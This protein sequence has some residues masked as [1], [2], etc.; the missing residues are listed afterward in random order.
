MV[1]SS[2]CYQ[3]QCC[4]HHIDD[5]VKQHHAMSSRFFP[6]QFCMSP[7]IS[8]IP[9]CQPSWPNKCAPRKT[10]HRMHI[11][12]QLHHAPIT[13][14]LSFVKPSTSRPSGC[15][16]SNELITHQ[17]LAR[18]I[19]AM[20]VNQ[21]LSASRL[22]CSNQVITHQL[23]AR[24]NIPTPSKAHSGHA[25][26]SASKHINNILLAVNKPTHHIPTSDYLRS[27]V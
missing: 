9:R 11:Y 13:M 23:L 24:H 18:H 7:A 26:Q 12:M 27:R 21:V 5:H 6:L 4:H 20:Q 17:L 25:G 10:S 1:V 22:P 14:H 16:R 15:L 8:T 19:L 3:V 2:S